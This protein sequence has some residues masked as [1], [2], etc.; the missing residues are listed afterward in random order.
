M[1]GLGFS[2]M[3]LP[4]LFAYADQLIPYATACPPLQTS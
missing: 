2:L 3:D 4:S 1:A